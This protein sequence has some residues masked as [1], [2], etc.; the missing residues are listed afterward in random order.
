MG[1]SPELAEAVSWWANWILVGALVV[2]VLAT[3]AVVV[4][5]NIRDSNLKRELTASGERIARLKHETARLRAK[6]RFVDEALLS[7]AQSGRANALA[8]TALRT[9]TEEIAI[10][11]GL[12]ISGNASEAARSLRIIPK[13]TPFAGK[14]FDAV[15]TSSNIELE[16][17][18][19]SLAAAL[20]AAGWI[21]VN[22]GDA[23]AI[24]PEQS[25]V[26]GAGLVR[27]DVDGS[28]DA[29]LLEAAETLASALNAEGIMASVNPKI[30]PDTTNANVIHILIDPTP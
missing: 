12:M 20:R 16:T 23:A 7:S 28:K 26:G 18:L 3:Y 14:Q 24:H 11:Q 15:A 9:L 21:E 2:G 27:I 30:T 8:A 25:S 4:S 6:E 22:R 19:G 17:L 10:S 1:M 29:K 5:G 13:V